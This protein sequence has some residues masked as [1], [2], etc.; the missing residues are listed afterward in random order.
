MAMHSWFVVTQ[1]AESAFDGSS[2][3][4]YPT[5][6]AHAKKMGTLHTA[7]GLSCATW[8]KLWE[9]PF[10]AMGGGNCPACLDALA[11]V[12]ASPHLVAKGVDRARA[13][14]R[15]SPRARAQ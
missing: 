9:V 7:C 14:E 5:S 4:R 11:R 12:C 6:L 1:F 8:E 13:P 2:E 15:P 10:P 3:S